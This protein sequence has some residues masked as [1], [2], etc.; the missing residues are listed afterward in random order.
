MFVN[1]ASTRTGGYMGKLASR[2]IP[3][4]NTKKISMNRFHS[5]CCPSICPLLRASNRQMVNPSQKR[6]KWKMP[7]NN[8]AHN[9]KKLDSVFLSLAQ[10]LAA[11]RTYHTTNIQQQKNTIQKKVHSFRSRQDPANAQLDRSSILFSW[12]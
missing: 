10:S 8:G 9:N 7:A 1:K 6:M 5:D 3:H 12:A 11:V 2:N 4:P